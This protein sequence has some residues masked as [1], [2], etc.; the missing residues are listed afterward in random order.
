MTVEIFRFWIR[1]DF[2]QSVVSTHPPQSRSTMDV[3][4]PFYRPLDKI[5]LT[6]LSFQPNY[7]HSLHNLLTQST[8]NDTATVKAVRLI[9]RANSGLQF[10]PSL[11]GYRSP[12]YR[13]LYISLVHTCTFSNNFRVS[14]STREF[15]R[16]IDGCRGE[17]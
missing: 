12:Q 2:Q 5:L 3:R 9:V 10:L 14:R 11:L 6:Y 17:I 1:S 8:S 13:V 15:N 4:T 7:V 16:R